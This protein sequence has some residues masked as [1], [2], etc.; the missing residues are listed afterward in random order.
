MIDIARQDLIFFRL[1][2]KGNLTSSLNI[3][4]VFWLS[5]YPFLE[6]DEE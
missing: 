1:I 5:H 6:N 4:H 3:L 2:S